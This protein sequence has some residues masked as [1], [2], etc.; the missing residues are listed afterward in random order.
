ML[1]I[2]SKAMI[3]ITLH[4]DP[5]TGLIKGKISPANRMLEEFFE[6]E[7][8]NDIAVIHYLS[9]RATDADGYNVEVTGNAFTLTL[10]AD[11]YIVSPLYDPDTAPHEGPREDFFF[12]LGEWR[13]FLAQ[14]TGQS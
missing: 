4:R 9:S 11:Q 3:D 13:K 6:T 8:Q 12:I 14:E 5:K 10:T 7:I 2:E 1:Q